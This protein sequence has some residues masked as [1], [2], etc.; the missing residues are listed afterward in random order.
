M[1]RMMFY[2]S[3]LPAPRHTLAS[4]FCRLHFIQLPSFA[5]LAESPINIWFSVMAAAQF[6]V[7][8]QGKKLT[9]RVHM[10]PEDQRN[11][12]KVE[13]VS[14]HIGPRHLLLRPRPRS[15]MSQMSPVCPRARVLGSVTVNLSWSQPAEPP[16]HS[17]FSK[18]TSNTRDLITTL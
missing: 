1:K 5:R 15:Q 2:L 7:C 9:S 12:G 4:L 17:A 8:K 18:Q 3:L 13:S 16:G 6:M 14:P 11:R 10:S